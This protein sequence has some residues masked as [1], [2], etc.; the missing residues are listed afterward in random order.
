MPAQK[1]A[2]MQRVRAVY[3]DHLLRVRGA[4]QH[5][6]VHVH[7]LCNREKS[8]FYRWGQISS[9]SPILELITLLY[10]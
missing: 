3:P 2:L 5:I 7:N 9:F 1:I 4:V 10:F 6:S 8:I